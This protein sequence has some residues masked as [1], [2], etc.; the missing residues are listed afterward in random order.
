MPWDP[1]NYEG[2]DRIQ[3]IEKY[4]APL[5]QASAFVVRDSQFAGGAKGDG[6]ADDTAAI[7]SA[8]TAANTQ[9]GSVAYVPAGTYLISSPLFVYSTCT[10]L[11]DAEATIKLK[12][13]SNCNMLQSPGVVGGARSTTSL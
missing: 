3:H 12:S 7:N 13:N 4:L 5:A 11:L 2:Q 10:L 8:M 9:T 1:V 6:V